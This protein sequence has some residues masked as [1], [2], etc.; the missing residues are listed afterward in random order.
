MRGPDCPAENETLAFALEPGAFAAFEICTKAAHLG[1]FE[2]ACGVA[3]SADGGSRANP[4]GR[5]D[6]ASSAFV[7]SAAVR[8]GGAA[9]VVVAGL[10]DVWLGVDAVGDEADDKLP[11]AVPVLVVWVDAEVA[12]QAATEADSASTTSAGG[13]SYLGWV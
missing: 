12:V 8:G 3:V 9:E 7:R 13:S 10:L 2:R 5:S 6:N 11:M 4:D 1:S